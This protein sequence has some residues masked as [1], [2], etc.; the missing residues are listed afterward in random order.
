MPIYII[1]MMLCCSH[2]FPSFSLS[3]SLAIYLYNP[4][5]PAGQ[6]RPNYGRYRLYFVNIVLVGDLIRWE[7]LHSVCNLG[8]GYDCNLIA[9]QINMQHCLI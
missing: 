3:L 1:I 9:T 8:V 5:L 7:L 2:G 4:S 6:N